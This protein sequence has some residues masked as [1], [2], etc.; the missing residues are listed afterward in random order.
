MP[1]FSS[2]STYDHSSQPWER[3]RQSYGY[4]DT[5]KRKCC[6]CCTTCLI[7]K[8]ITVLVILIAAAIALFF[9]LAPPGGPKEWFLHL[10]PAGLKAAHRW[11]NSGYGGLKLTILNAVDNHYEALVYT[12]IHRWDNG[13]PDALS[14]TTQNVTHDSDC[15]PVEGVLKVCNGDYGNTGWRGIDL[16]TLYNGYIINSAVKMNDYYLDNSKQAWKDYT[17]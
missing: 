9:L 7:I 4:G 8:C 13:T 14:L 10:P 6:R 11:D 5:N 3:P 12:W 2:A 16:S 1:L 17:M 15:A